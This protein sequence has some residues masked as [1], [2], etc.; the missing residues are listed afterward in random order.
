MIKKKV[1]KRGPAKR[2]RR[3]REP[4]GEI[5]LPPRIPLD[6]KDSPQTLLPPCK[7]SDYH[8]GSAN[9][10]QVQHNEG[11]IKTTAYQD[12]DDADIAAGLNLTEHSASELRSYVSP[13]STLGA[14]LAAYAGQPWSYAEVHPL[15]LTSS[16]ADQLQDGAQASY[17][18]MLSHAWGQTNS[19][20]GWS[21]LSAG[22]KTAML[23]MYWNTGNYSGT[24]EAAKGFW[25]A[26]F[27][28]QWSDAATHLAKDANN[29]VGG[30]KAR[31][32]QDAKDIEN[33]VANH[34]APA[35]CRSG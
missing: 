9:W 28:Q 23:D 6:A 24:T 34:D 27:A 10:A 2:V 19:T 4:D 20:V 22:I 7:A 8:A 17:E 3:N 16:Q 11:G 31:R 25:S 5:P 18:T 12:G 35:A 30:D 14:K 29:Y 13:D 32:Q 26:A 21:D 15:S 33:D 1:T